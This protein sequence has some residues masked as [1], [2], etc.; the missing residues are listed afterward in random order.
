MLAI[1]SERLV[2]IGTLITGI[3]SVVVVWLRLTPALLTRR[4]AIRRFD[5]AVAR[6]DSATLEVSTETVRLVVE[7]SDLEPSLLERRLSRTT[8]RRALLGRISC[9]KSRVV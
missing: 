2:V 6:G 4:A 5:E 8:H 9:W 7:R 1:A 3:S